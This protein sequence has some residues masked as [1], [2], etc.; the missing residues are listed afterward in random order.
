MRLA[1]GSN[2]IDF[3]YDYQGR[4]YSLTYNGT[5][6]YYVLN[7]QGDVV[8]IVNA[9]GAVQASYTYDAWGNILSSSGTLAD[10]NPLRYRGYVFDAET[11]LYYLNSR[12]Y[13]PANRRMLSPDDL[14]LLNSSQFALVDKNLFSYCD[15]NAVVRKDADGAFWDTVLDAASVVGDIVEIAANPAN[16]IAWASLA[17]DAVSLAVPCVTGGGTIVRVV[18]NG[19]N[20]MDVTKYVDDIID[21]SKTIK[22]TSEHGMEL[23]HLYD[24]IKDLAQGL[25]K[26]FNKALEGT[27]LRPDAI[28]NA[29]KVIY[30]LKPYNRRALK[31]AIKQTAGYAK[32]Y[33]QKCTVV[34]DMYLF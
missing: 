23:H 30:E 12:Y 5:T 29:H 4:P 26:R 19:D 9:S 24:P 18:A 10:V 17:A 3:A 31:K 1:W 14:S 8:R 7:L 27:R 34:I 15:N 16:P 13:D 6:Y 2:K 33:G 28:D 20:I 22:S 32:A 11:G 25:D 21:A